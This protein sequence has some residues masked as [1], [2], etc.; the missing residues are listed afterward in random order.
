MRN[1]LF[2]LILVMVMSMSMLTTVYGGQSSSVKITL[3]NFKVTMNGEVVNN[4]YSKYPLIVYNNITYFPMTYSDC[5]Y[6]GIESTWKGNKEGLLVD[7]TGV[8]AAYNPYKSSSKNSRSYT[9]KIPSFPI[10]VNGKAID[11]SKE[12]YPLLSFRDITY[13][14]MTWKYGVEQFGWDYS[15]DGKNGLVIKSKNIKLQQI[16]LPND[17]PKEDEYSKYA[18]KKSTCVMVKNGYVYFDNKTGGIMQ[19]PIAN[20]S[21]TKKIYQ[22]DRNF[23]T[24]EYNSHNFYEENGKAMLFFHSGGAVMGADWRIELNSDG[25]TKEIQSSYDETTAFGDRLFSYFV[26]PAPGPNNLYMQQG[27][28][29]SANIGDSRYWYYGL[30]WDNDSFP[31]LALIGDDL[32]V[33]ARKATADSEHSQLQEDEKEIYLYKVNI[34]NNKTV[35]INNKPTMSAQIIGNKIYYLCQDK[36]YKISLD[37]SNEELVGT[38]NNA[39]VE[40]Y[41]SLFAVLGEKVY[42]KNT[43]DHTLYMLGQEKPLN[44]GT[45]LLDMYLRGDSKEYL[46]CHFQETPVSKYR[47]MVLDKSGKVVFRTSDTAANVTIEGKQM[48]FYDIATEKV[49]TCT[50]N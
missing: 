34:K 35:Q 8:T 11:N 16:A 22:L 24:Q 28:G 7:A 15:F 14:P 18:G 37:G 48:C 31:K 2:S 9:A 33:R 42:W 39:S 23:Y 17:R 46:V 12:Q 13:F 5:R 6:L 30:I 1:K 49:C 47:L 38:L 32:Y 45:I 4:D 40:Q 10:K 21:K 44:D 3:P 43:K 20:T 36:L 41:Q 29:E 25:T 27:K 26:G 19:A 50:L